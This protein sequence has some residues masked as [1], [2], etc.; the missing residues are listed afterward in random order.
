MDLIKQKEWFDSPKF[1]KEYHCDAPLGAFLT[2]NG[3][4]FYLW[5]PTADEV[6]LVLYDQGEGDSPFAT[7]SVQ[8]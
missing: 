6:T 8:V 1:E 7:R 2:P 3:T 5:A 4:A